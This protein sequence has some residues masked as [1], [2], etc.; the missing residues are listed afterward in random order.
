VFGGR[1]NT[2]LIWESVVHANAADRRGTHGRE[3]SRLCQRHRQEG[4]GSRRAP[5]GA[6]VRLE[7]DAACGVM[8]AT[9]HPAASR[10]ATTS[11]LSKKVERGALR[12]ALSEKLKAG[13]LVVVD[14]PRRDRGQDQGGRRDA[15]ATRH[16]RQGGP[17]G[18]RRRREAVAIGPQHSGRIARAQRAAHR[19]P[20][21]SVPAAWSATRS[22]LEKLQEALG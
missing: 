20:R 13:E 6:Q 8:A 1:I 11:K 7:P 4:R 21:S 18:R 12:A 3:D 22:A 19:A 9:V 2:D 14:A 16:H 5:G 15:E 17:G 10:A